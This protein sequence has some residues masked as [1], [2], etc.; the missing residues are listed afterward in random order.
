M[1]SK[2]VALAA[3]VTIG[4]AL[5]GPDAAPAQTYPSH[6]ITMGMPFAAGGPGDVLARILAERMRISS[7][8]R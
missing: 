3:V 7:A 8:S 2:G 4:I 5:T 1:L 6:P